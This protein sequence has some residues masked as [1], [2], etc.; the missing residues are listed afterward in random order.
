MDQSYQTHIQSQ[1]RV[2]STRVQI[3]VAS[4]RVQIRV[5][6]TRVHDM[7]HFHSHPM[8]KIR[9]S[10]THVHRQIKFRRGAH[11]AVQKMAIAASDEEVGP[12][13]ALSQLAAK[14]LDERAYGGAL[15][16]GEGSAI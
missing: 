15:L 8:T 10:E 9:R 2:A 6:S 3:W 4:T 1:I 11:Q 13:P 7:S 5:A 16:C 12:Q 14:K